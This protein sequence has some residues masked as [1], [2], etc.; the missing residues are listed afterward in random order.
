[1]LRLKM[2]PFVLHGASIALRGAPIDFRRDRG[3]WQRRTPGRLTAGLKH[4]EL[5][6]E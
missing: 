5:W 6:F 2:Q 4:D 1:V 3:V